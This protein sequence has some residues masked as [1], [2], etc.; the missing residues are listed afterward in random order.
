MTTKYVAGSDEEQPVHPV[1]EPAVARQQPAH[2]L[3]PEVAL[4]H[5]LA[6]IPERGHDGDH[7]AEHE[8]L[9]DGPRDG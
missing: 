8:R 4:D 5:R 6:Q 2:V 9:A 7:D 1:E 3:Q